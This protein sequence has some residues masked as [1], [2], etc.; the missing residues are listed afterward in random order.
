MNPRNWVT[1]SDP[2]KPLLAKTSADGVGSGEDPSIFP[3]LTLGLATDGTVLL[4]FL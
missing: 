3:A 1:V 2:Y 4:K